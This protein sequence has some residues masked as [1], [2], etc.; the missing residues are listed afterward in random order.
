MVEA[1]E[2]YMQRALDLAELGKE[3]VSPNPMVGCVIVH[4]DKI[5]GEGYHQKYGEAHAEVNAIANVEDES[6][7]PNSTLYVTLE[8]CSHYGKIPPCADLIVRK[9]LKKVVVCNNDPNPLVAGRG[10]GK[11]KKAGIEVV[12]GVLAEKGEQVNRRF[13]TFMRRQRPYIILKWAETAD[14]FIARKNFDSKWI[15]NEFSRKLV[16]QWRA[17][18]DAIMVGTNTALHDNPKLNVRDWEGKNPMRVVIDRH[19]KLPS[20]LHL[21]DQSQNTLCFN[22]TKDNSLENLEFFKLPES[23]FLAQLFSTLYQKKVQSIIVEGGSAL[24]K[25]LIAQNLW[26]EM[27]VFKSET[28]FG[29][30]ISAPKVR[31][32]KVFEKK[33][34]NDILIVYQNIAN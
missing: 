15:S 6:L 32:K 21:F 16:H 28:S 25:S 23:G 20:T 8:P 3:K 29:E 30:G 10:L 7:F 22:L 17:E 1:E 11:L 24:L 2:K 4:D 34:Q 33:I 14:G 27:R 31:G 12:E 13:F 19:L 18:E 26:D 5:I 9:Q